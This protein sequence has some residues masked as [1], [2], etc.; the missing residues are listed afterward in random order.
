[1]DETRRSQ[2]ELKQVQEKV[3]NSRLV[4]IDEVSMVFN[5]LLS[6]IN[7]VMNDAC[8][9]AKSPHSFFGN[10]QVLLCGDFY[11]L[12]PIRQRMIL[13]SATDNLIRLWDLFQP[14]IFKKNHRQRE[15][16]CF[17]TILEVM[18]N[19]CLSEESDNLLIQRCSKK[20]VN[21]NGY[22]QILKEY[23][24]HFL[25]SLHLF[26]MCRQAEDFDRQ[27]LEECACQLEN[28]VWTV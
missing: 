14:V 27:K 13:E 2:K 9:V 18:R 17:I 3:L 19:G 11:Q 5:E 7:T 16:I 26:V 22:R 12:R 4:I 21:P 28:L 10:K 20:R 24:E 8:D 6:Q 1:M 23:K 15:D 25:N